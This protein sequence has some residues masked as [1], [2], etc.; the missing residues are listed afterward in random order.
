MRLAVEHAGYPLIPRRKLVADVTVSS[1]ALTRAVRLADDLYR[2]LEARGHRVTIAAA[3]EGFIRI[4]TDGTGPGGADGRK[5]AWSPLRPTV[6]Y[7]FGVPVGLAITETYDTARMRYVGHG[8]FI[9]ERD[10][11]EKDHVG[12]TWWVDRRV[13]T[14]RLSLIAYSPVHR[15]PWSWRWTETTERPMGKMLEEIL[16]R[17][18]SGAL[19]FGS[20]LDSVET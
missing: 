6:A 3:F 17:L 2:G 10:Y 9:R 11:R 4:P 16:L 7:I 12:P 15:V 18:E 13:P 1:G 20:R 14:G 5:R 8:R 19:D